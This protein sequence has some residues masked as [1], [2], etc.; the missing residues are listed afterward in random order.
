MEQHESLTHLAMV[1]LDTGEVSS[2]MPTEVAQNMLCPGDDV[3]IPFKTQSD[4]DGVLDGKLAL[5]AFTAQLVEDHWF[6]VVKGEYAQTPLL[7]HLLSP[8]MVNMLEDANES[9]NLLVIASQDKIRFELKSKSE[10][11]AQNL[12]N[13]LV[14]MGAVP[15]RV[16]LTKW[17][18]PTH[19]LCDMV[20]SPIDL[21]KLGTVE[22]PTHVA[23]KYS[24]LVEPGQLTLGLKKE[25]E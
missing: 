9:T 20:V 24:I 13:L 12:K 2:I 3:F 4:I 19:F 23:V 17:N 22:L 25:P 14:R 8:A 15:I 18:D 11:G 21:M 5:S 7:P 6:A 1:N 16:Y 10:S